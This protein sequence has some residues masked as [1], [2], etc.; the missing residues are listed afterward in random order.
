[1]GSTSAFKPDKTPALMYGYLRIPVGI[2]LM[3]LMSLMIRYQYRN[4]GIYNMDL[5]RCACNKKHDACFKASFPPCL[6]KSSCFF[7]QYASLTPSWLGCLSS[8]RMAWH[9]RLTRQ[10]ILISS[11]HRRLAYKC[12][13]LETYIGVSNA[14]QEKSRSLLLM[15][16]CCHNLA[17]NCKDCWNALQR[18]IASQMFS[19]E[20]CH[21]QAHLLCT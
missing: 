9:G 15:L 16:A 6:L 7:N 17:E 21:W 20:G 1:M 5:P 4:N 19:Q 18:N 14:A 11:T 10:L 8:I 13:P 12:L 2:L 3:S